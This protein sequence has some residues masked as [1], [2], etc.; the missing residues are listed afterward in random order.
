MNSLTSLVWTI[1][2]KKTVTKTIPSKISS[3]QIQAK[4]IAWICKNLR[5]RIFIFNHYKA[6]SLMSQNSGTY[7]DKIKESLTSKVGNLWAH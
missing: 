6:P 4:S 7:I 2:Q 3:L 5:I 1:R